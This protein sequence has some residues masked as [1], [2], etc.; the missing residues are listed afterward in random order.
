MEKKSIR[1]ASHAGSWYSDDEDKLNGQLSDWL[2]VATITFPDRKARA[3]IGPH[4]GY[5]YSGAVAAYS[6]KHIVPTGIKRVFVFGPSHHVS[7]DGCAL[8]TQT[9]YET[10]LGELTLDSEVIKK[11]YDTKLFGKMTK[12]V[13]EAEHSIELHLPYIAKMFHDQLSTVKIVPVLVGS[14]Q[15]DQSEQYAQIFAKYLDNDENF[16]IISSDFCH[17]GKRFSYQWHD[18]NHGDI[19]DSIEWLDRQ[20]MSIIE[21]LSPEQ[22]RKYRKK[23][24]NTICGRN[25][26]LL[27]LHTIQASSGKWELKFVDYAQSSKCKSKSDSSV[28]YAAGVLWPAGDS[29]NSSSSTSSS[30]SK[31]TKTKK[32]EE[33]SGGKRKREKD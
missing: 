19:C 14:A 18:P 31:E 4:A 24:E 9:H 22:F 10:P 23:Y 30:S 8:S 26:I 7:V 27:L 21:T 20:G 6:Y 11:L 32:K 25:P 12:S 1:L 17:W 13:D 5:S 16:F 2:K 15:K 29:S 33:A 3:I 28:S